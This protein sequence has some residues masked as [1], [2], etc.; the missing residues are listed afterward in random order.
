MEATTSAK[1]FW[2]THY[3]FVLGGGICCTTRGVTSVWA[4]RCVPLSRSGEQLRQRYSVMH[5]TQVVLIL[6]CRIWQNG[7]IGATDMTRVKSSKVGA[8]LVCDRH[9]NHMWWYN[10]RQCRLGSAHWSNKR[11]V[12]LECEEWS[13]K[14]T[15]KL[16]GRWSWRT[17]TPGNS[18]KG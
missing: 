10:C 3:L 5:S 17:T 15:M 8:I 12:G 16:Q 13:L 4:N 14:D 6:G 11:W 9:H 18:T 2:A 7:H 1:G